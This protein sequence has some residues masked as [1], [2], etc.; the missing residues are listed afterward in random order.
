M[1]YG[2][3]GEG[4]TSL[5]AQFDAPLFVITSGEQG[6]YHLKKSGV[7]SKDIPVVQLDPLYPEDSI[8][9]GQGHPGWEKAIETLQVFCK[10]QHDRKTIVY[11]TTSGL[12][13]LCFQH[14]ASK[15]FGGDMESRT[16]DTWNHYANGPRKAASAYWQA[17]FLNLCLECKMKGYNVILLAHSTSKT[18]TNLDGPD[19]EIYQPQ[20]TNK[21][22]D[23]T[24]KD[25]SDCMFLGKRMQFI[26][27]QKTKKRSVV[28]QER[29]IGVES[30]TWYVAKNWENRHDE[31]EAGSSPAESYTNL[32]SAMKG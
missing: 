27:D 11:D 26:T 29:F 30:S 17:E 28:G 14:C 3:P 18:V 21:V 25:L 24:S 10:G 19:Y 9:V 16:Q 31:I 12:E 4:K 23:Y 5:A 15:Q 2:P 13:A 32:M 6:I 20:L 1:F 7:A 8:P 22:W